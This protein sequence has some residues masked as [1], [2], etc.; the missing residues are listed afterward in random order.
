MQGFPTI[1]V[2]K[3]LKVPIKDIEISNIFVSNYEQYIQF[4]S[5]VYI[6]QAEYAKC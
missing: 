1:L 2:P 3:K 4:C 5:Y 6:L